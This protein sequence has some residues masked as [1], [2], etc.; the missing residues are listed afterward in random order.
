VLIQAHIARA[1]MLVVATPDTFRVRAMI[2]TA[3][4]LNP[5]IKTVVRSHSESEADL[6]RAEHAGK[7]FLG[8]HEL[9]GSMASYVL[10]HL[11]PK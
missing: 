8:E 11:Q 2:E 9:A 3:R 10:E 5:A 6:L 1:S 4:A 7:V